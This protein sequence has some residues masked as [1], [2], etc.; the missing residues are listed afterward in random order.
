[1]SKKGLFEVKISFEKKPLAKAKG[2]R[3]IDF[4][5]LFDSLKEKFGEKPE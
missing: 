5:E 2:N 4:D 1:M 3:I